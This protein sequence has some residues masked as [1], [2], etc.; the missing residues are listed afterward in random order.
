MRGTEP[1]L[2]TKSFIASSRNRPPSASPVAES[3]V[4][5][6]TENSRA[7]I[8]RIALAKSFPE[9]AVRKPMPPMF[10]P[11]IGVPE[12]AVFLAHCSIVPSPPNTMTKSA[13]CALASSVIGFIPAAA[14][15]LAA[16]CTIRRA[17]GLEALAT[18]AIF[19]TGL[20][21]C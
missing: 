7:A 19:L 14:A 16:R 3:S 10:T 13:E 17:A 21:T 5:D 2:M 6:S 18:R 11:K 4:R 15:S 8:D 12:P 1:R 9:T 20:F